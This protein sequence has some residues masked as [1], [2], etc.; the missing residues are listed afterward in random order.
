MSRPD[1][2]LS[3]IELVAAIAISSAVVVG[4]MTFYLSQQRA[5][6][7]GKMQVDTSQA[8]RTAIDQISRDLRVAGRNPTLP[9]TCG[10]LVADANEVDFTFDEND[11]GDCSDDGEQ[12]GFR[13]QGTTLQARVAV[14]TLADWETLVEDLVATGSIFSYYM[15]PVSGTPVLVTGLPASSADRAAIVRVDVTLRF[16][17]T[18]P[19][20][21][22]QRVET[23]SVILRNRTL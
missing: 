5:L 20:G 7:H 22:I 15:P 21:G 18:A 9:N 13:R 11:D 14:G 10:F 3:L 23:A 19:L 16:S 17:R 4:F 12:K 1:R 6:Q 2:G 8:I